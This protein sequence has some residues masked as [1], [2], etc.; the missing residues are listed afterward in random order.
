M[1]I[2]ANFFKNFEIPKKYKGF[3]FHFS[4]K[5]NTIKVYKD[6]RDIQFN[7][8]FVN[9]LNGYQK[10]YMVTWSIKFHKTQNFESATIYA[11]NDYFNNN[12]PKE[13][14]EKI[15]FILRK[16]N[17]TFQSILN[18]LKNIFNYE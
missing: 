6:S 15:K 2:P 12:L 10:Y 8:K 1:N 11:M 9:M 4:D 16:H 3:K 14:F 17:S 13:D 7:P 5:V 18:F